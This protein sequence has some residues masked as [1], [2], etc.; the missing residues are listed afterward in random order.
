MPEAEI[1][2]LRYW[3]AL[4]DARH[5]HDT[6]EWLSFYGRELL[7]YLP[8]P[9]G[10]VLELGCGNGDLYGTMRHRFAA[11][12]GIDF[13]RAM[14]RRFRAAWPEA[15]LVVADVVDLPLA[16]HRFDTVFS[17]GVCQ[18]LDAAGLARHLDQVRAL[19]SPGGLVLLGNIPDAELRWHCYAGALGADREVRP[20]QLALRLAQRALLGQPD[21]M[22]HWYSRARLCRIAEAHG[23]SCR[24]HSSASYEYR[25]HAVLRPRPEPDR[26][27]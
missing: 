6:P 16:G 5:R 2:W 7:L 12:L 20:V 10:R 15:R 14:I 17:N 4:D 24:T 27:P 21:E 13:S 11:Y 9:P 23:F 3:A 22:G 25:F 18:Y 19:V 1:D 26:M 8:D